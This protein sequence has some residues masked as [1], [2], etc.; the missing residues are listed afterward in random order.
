MFRQDPHWHWPLGYTDRLGYPKGE[1]IA[2]VDLN[3]LVAILLKPLSPWLPEPFQYLGLEVVLAC[4]L[5]L[6]FAFRLFRL[7]LGAAPLKVLLPSLFFLL[8]PPLTYRFV[9]HYSLS[10]HWVVV[11]ALYLFF[12]AHLDLNVQRLA[13][14]TLA[15]G[16]VA[17]AINPYTWLSRC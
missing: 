8:S 2:I 3:P 7:L 1:S 9:G 6:F 12:R 15:L 13:V 11:A 5:L 14:S 4:I 10:N 17:V 16:G